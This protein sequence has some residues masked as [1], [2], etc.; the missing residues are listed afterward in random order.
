MF[1]DAWLNVN[2]LN[3]TY[4]YSCSKISCA[5]WWKIYVRC[6]RLDSYQARQGRPGDTRNGEKRGDDLE[7]YL[8][9]DA[10]ARNYL[11]YNDD[12]EAA[13]KYFGTIISDYYDKTA[14]QRREAVRYCMEE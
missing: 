14:V 6:G 10:S 11:A 3:Q 12:G 4:I 2:Y 9:R 7:G 5:V 8:D 1:C 13:R